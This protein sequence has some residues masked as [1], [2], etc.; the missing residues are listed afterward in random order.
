[1]KLEIFY[2]SKNGDIRFDAPPILYNDQDFFNYDYSFDLLNIPSGKS[3]KIQRLTSYGKTFTIELQVIG[4]NKADIMNMLHDRFKQ[5]IEQYIET[6]E[7]P[8]LYI[9]DTYVECLLTSKVSNGWNTFKRYENITIQVLAPNPNWIK[10]DRFTYAQRE[11][12]YSAEKEAEFTRLPLRIPFRLS[13]MNRIWNIRNE[14]YADANIKIELEGPVINPTIYIGDRTYR[15]F[16]EIMENERL[17]INQRDKT[18]IRLAPDGTAI[19]EFHNR[20]KEHSPF[21]PIGSGDNQV[22]IEG[23]FYFEIIVYQERSEP[24]WS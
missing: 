16:V 15:V 11:E 20:D 4:N 10:E 21:V 8:R 5:D 19:N 13:E 22:S 7:L 18:V 3:S 12:T 2:R 9:G 17:V 6:N 14:S 23:N 1:M 24:L